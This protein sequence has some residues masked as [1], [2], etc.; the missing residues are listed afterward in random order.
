MMNQSS[1]NQSIH[2]TAWLNLRH[3]TELDHHLQK[4]LPTLQKQIC[5]KN[6]ILQLIEKTHQFACLDIFPSYSFDTLESAQQLQGN[7]FSWQIHRKTRLE[8]SR[9]AALRIPTFTQ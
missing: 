7:F 8:T 1:R 6:D 2:T 4:I 5:L 3:V 9:K